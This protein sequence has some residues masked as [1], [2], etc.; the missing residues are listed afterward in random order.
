M[1][2]RK[3]LL[4]WVL[5]PVLAA[6]ILCLWCWLPE[7]LTRSH[8]SIITRGA[9]GDTF[10]SVNALFTGF[11]FLVLIVT[12]VLQK[13]ELEAQREELES[14]REELEGQKV[15]LANQSETLQLQRFENTFFELQRVSISMASKV[16]EY[17][18]GN[19]ENEIRA[20]LGC[21]IQTDDPSSV[22]RLGDIQQKSEMT[23]SVFVA[24]VFDRVFSDTSPPVLP[25]LRQLLRLVEFVDASPVG[26]KELYIGFVQ[27]Q[28]SPGIFQKILYFGLSTPGDGYRP[29]IEK[30]GL[31]R[32]VPELSSFDKWCSELYDQSAFEEPQ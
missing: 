7:H 14:T 5:L 19:F 8:S 18:L 23:K 10:G 32:H 15:Q 25:C 28:L 12:M 20:V 29:L 11:A 9:Y 16:G 22:A 31:L 24:Q 27:A 21:K 17:Y 26:V 2:I 1:R 30:Y 4:F 6:L 13:W 3:P